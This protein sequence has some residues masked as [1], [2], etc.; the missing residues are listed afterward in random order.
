MRIG[1]GNYQEPVFIANKTYK[2]LL[3]S[4]YYEPD[5]MSSKSLK[6]YICRLIHYVTYTDRP[7][8]R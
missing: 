8:T 4:D 5:R 3:I 1:R 7:A 2:V 6:A